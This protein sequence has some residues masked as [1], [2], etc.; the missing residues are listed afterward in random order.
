MKKSLSYRQTAELKSTIITHQCCAISISAL[1][2]IGEQKKSVSQ[3][4]TFVKTKV[5][6]KACFLVLQLVDKVKE[7][8]LN[9]QNAFQICQPLATRKGRKLHDLNE[10]RISSR[11]IKKL[12]QFC[13]CF[14]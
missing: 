12:Q 6:L 8:A 5:S 7:K 1:H 2:L 13:K 14:F 9:F 10:I 3:T 11:Y 4:I